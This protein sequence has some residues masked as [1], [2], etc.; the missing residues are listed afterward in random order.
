MKL[1]Q[2]YNKICELPNSFKNR[3]LEEYLLA[4]YKNVLI[5]KNSKPTFELVLKIFYDSF[6][7]E[8]EKFDPDWLKITNAPDENRMSRKFTNPEISSS[9]NKSSISEFQGIDFTFQT[10]RFQIAEL[11]KMRDKQLKNEM[12]YFGLESETGNY[13]YNFDPFGNLECGVRCMID[14]EQDNESID[15]S[16]I[17]EILENGRIYE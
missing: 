11:H 10:L 15:W 7:S 2:F 4:V 16:I 17:G 8:P 3:E 9:I 14:N 1:E 6:T 13:W 12:R 5:H